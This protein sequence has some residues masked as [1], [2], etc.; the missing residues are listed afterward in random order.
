MGEQLGNFHV[1]FELDGACSEVYSSESLYLGKKSYFENLE[2]T[3]KNSDI[4]NGEHIR[5]KAIPTPCIKYTAQ[6]NN[7]SVLELYKTLF[8]NDV[9]GFYLTNDN[10]KFVCR[11][12]KDYTISNIYKGD[13][14]SSRKIKFIRN[15]N[16]KIFIH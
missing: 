3:D 5:M 4:I 2:S 13:S 11:N 16:D 12:N 9:I 1:D 15:N 7:T 6:Q 8:N 10:N 14:C